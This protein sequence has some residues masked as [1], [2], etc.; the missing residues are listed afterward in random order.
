MKR[1]F[2]AIALLL[3]PAFSIAGYANVNDEQIITA[4][5]RKYADE[6]VYNEAVVA[7]HISATK[8]KRV[9]LVKDGEANPLMID[10]I[11]LQINGGRAILVSRLV[12]SGRKANGRTYQHVNR[13]TVDLV[14]QD[15][16]WQVVSAQVGKIGK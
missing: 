14:K 16:E 6:A 15:G 3:I 7:K 8:P 2:V 11:K 12:L 10:Q 13:W 5:A 4:L 1:I 9:M